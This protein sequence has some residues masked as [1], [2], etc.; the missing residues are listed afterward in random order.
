MQRIESDK[1]NNRAYVWGSGMVVRT[2]EIRLLY[3]SGFISLLTGRK[4]IKLGAGDDSE[5]CKWFLLVEKDLFFNKDLMFKHYIEPFRLTVEYYKNMNNGF[6]LSSRALNQYDF[7]LFLL[8]KK[9]KGYF[10]SIIS[11]FVIVMFERNKLKIKMLLEFLNKTPLTFH[12]QTS[13]ILKSRKLFI[14][15]EKEA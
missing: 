1:I 3:N 2:K 4:G 9:E 5:I 11:L 13:N 15:N 14:E 10:F 6:A 8:K 7:I 12:R